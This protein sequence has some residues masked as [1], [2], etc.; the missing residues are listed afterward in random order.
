MAEKL[1]HGIEALGLPLDLPGPRVTASFGVAARIPDAG[2]NPQDLVD[3]AD[4][5]LY[6]AKDQGRNRVCGAVPGKLT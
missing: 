6:E 1:R 2:Q 3:E 4:H 5:A